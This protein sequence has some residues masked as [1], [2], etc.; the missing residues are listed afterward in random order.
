[1]ATGK[2]QE[3]G[4]QAVYCSPEG[5]STSDSSLSHSCFPAIPGNNAIL[6]TAP[7]LAS[8]VTGL[9]GRGHET[10]PTSRHYIADAPRDCYA[11]PLTSVAFYDFKGRA[12]T[13][14]AGARA[15]D[16]ARCTV[17]LVNQTVGLGKMRLSPLPLSRAH[18]RSLNTAGKILELRI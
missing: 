13:S 1:M 17:D 16:E 5:R 18:A 4:P 8:I 7:I 15:R 2:K 9:E 10:A 3:K 12:S 14:R 6:I 11:R